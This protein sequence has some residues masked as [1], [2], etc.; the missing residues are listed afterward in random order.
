M[1]RQILDA[2]P[3]IAEQADARIVEREADIADLPR[4]RV[5]RIGPLEMVHDLREPI[6][7]LGLDRQRF[8][9]LARRAPPAVRDHV[10]GHARAQA[11]VPLVDVLNDPLAA[12]TARQIEIDVGPLPTFLGQESLEQQVHADRVHGRD[13]QAVTH[14]TV[15]SRPASLHEDVVL[16]TKVHDV[17]DDEEVAGEIE[18]L[19]E[20]QLTRDLPART[21]V[22]RSVSLARAD[23]RHLPQERAHRFA[24]WDRVVG[25]PVAEIGHRVRQA[26]GQLT[27]G[28]EGLRQI[29]KQPRHRDRLFQ[30]SLGVPLETPASA[31]DRGL[32]ADACEEIVERSI[33]DDRK[34]YAVGR[35]DRHVERRGQRDQRLIIGFF[36]PQQVPLQ[37]DIHV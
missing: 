31:I 5:L 30:I 16:S 18:P 9:D 6:D 21:L 10:R 17:P 29:V 32:V 26:I 22:V 13:A 15:R 3:Q 8:A 34:P 23:L 1:P 35:H 37:L 24:G 4:Q 7:P 36:V 33:V 25:K 19:D 12:I 2:L 28:V 27:R 20:I 14:G 11:A